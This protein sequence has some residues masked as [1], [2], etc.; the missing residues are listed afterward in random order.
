V[1][2][3]RNMLM[4]GAAESNVGK[5][6]LACLL[7]GRFSRLGDVVAVK[8]T[9]IRETDGSCPRGGEGCGVCS[10]FEGRYCITEEGAA[11]PDK[12][13]ARM[14]ASG[15]GR[16]LWLRV[17]EDHLEE[18]ATALVESIGRAQAVICESNSLRR[19]IEPG[20]F[21][22]VKDG[23]SNRYKP[24]A[25][26][27]RKHADRIVRYDGETFDI[28]IDD[29]AFSGGAWMLKAAATAIVMAGGKSSRMGRDKAMLPVDGRPMI[30][31][32]CDLIRPHFGQLLISAGDAGKY[33]FLGIETVAD[34]IPGRGPLVGIASALEASAHELNAVVACD[35]P[36]INIDFIKRM[37]KECE[38]Y[39][40]VVPRTGVSFLE[41]LCAVYRKSMAGP[42]ND[43]LSAGEIKLSDVLRRCN[44]RFIDTRDVHSLRN[45]NTTS[46][47]DKYVTERRGGER[48]ERHPV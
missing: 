11:P 33:S 1:I 40:A 16:V 46:E 14:H 6:D 20:M 23:S 44:V 4:I 2:T 26:E 41:P 42:L 7:I 30:E 28:D 15:A 27:M 48:Q 36:D 24:S 45:I 25:R 19:I 43:A 39:D 12:D 35:M 21:L 10:G 9:T 38:G 47:Y 31:H 17:M 18:G 37:I 29:I 5:T 22:M 32:I 34:K 13:T 3:L 8:V